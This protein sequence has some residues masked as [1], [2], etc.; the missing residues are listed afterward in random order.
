MKNFPKLKDASL[1]F[2]TD[3]ISNPNFIFSHK[4]DGTACIIEITSDAVTLTGRGILK[5]GEQQDYT[6]KFPEI[7]QSLQ[8]SEQTCTILGEIVIFDENGVDRFDCLQLRTTRKKDIEKY[9]AEFPAQFIA[10][11]IIELNGKNLEQ[12]PLYYRIEMLDAVCEEL[13]ITAI[14]QDGTAFA[15]EIMID[16]MEKN[17][18]EG[19][20]AKNKTAEY[21]KESYKYKM[22]VTEDVWCDGEY[23]NGQGRN[24]NRVGS[25]LCFQYIAGEKCEVGYVRGF[26]DELCQ[27]F[28]DDIKS[29]IINSKDPLILEVKS[30]KRIKPSNKLRHASFTRIRKDKD[31]SQCVYE[32]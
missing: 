3:A 8:N 22:T 17:E 5:S 21:G 18:W 7:I 26:T 28:T 27:Q 9:A 15:K 16:V 25:L 13:K 20:V 10:F 4:Y 31:K 6:N 2:L 14:T 12:F 32:P 1:Q 19:I 30:Y 23:R 29:G 11:D 24:K